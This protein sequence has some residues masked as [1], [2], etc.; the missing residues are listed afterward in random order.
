MKGWTWTALDAIVARTRG[1][2]FEADRWLAQ[3]GPRGRVGHGP[4]DVLWRCGRR[5]S[6]W[7]LSMRKHLGDGGLLAPFRR[8]RPLNKGSM[9]LW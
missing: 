7:R 8:S 6:S 9:A 4:A 1:W 5:D 3:R 2:V